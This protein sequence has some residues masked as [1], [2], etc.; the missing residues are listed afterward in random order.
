VGLEDRCKKIPRLHLFVLQ[1]DFPPWV[2][3]RRAS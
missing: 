3:A 1:I 2:V